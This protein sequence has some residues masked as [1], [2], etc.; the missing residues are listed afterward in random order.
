MTD[1]EIPGDRSLGRRD[2][3]AVGL[4]QRAGFVAV[5]EITNRVGSRSMRIVFGPAAVWIARPKSGSTASL[6]S[7]A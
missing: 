4:Y 2:N 6:E 5:G 3:P 7:P 1:G